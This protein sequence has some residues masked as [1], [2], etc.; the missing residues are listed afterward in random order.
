MTLNNV[1]NNTQMINKTLLP[2][3]ET[4]KTVNLKKSITKSHTQLKEDKLCTRFSSAPVLMKYT[5]YW[6][7]N[8]KTNRGQ[9]L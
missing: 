8:V 1:S 7:R 4:L 2:S 6:L 3:S 5:S 9:V